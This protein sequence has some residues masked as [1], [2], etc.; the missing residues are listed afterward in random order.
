VSLWFA[1]V[2][3]AFTLAEGHAAERFALQLMWSNPAALAHPATKPTGFDQTTGLVAAAIVVMQALPL[4]FP[5]LSSHGGH[6]LADIACAMAS[7]IAAIAMFFLIARRW[8]ALRA[9][10]ACTLMSLGIAALFTTLAGSEVSAARPHVSAHLAF[11]LLGLAVMAGIWTWLAGVWQQQLDVAVAW[12]PAGRL[13]SIL[14][15]MVWL[16]A[17]LGAAIGLRLGLKASSAGAAGV[18]RLGATVAA[19]AGYLLLI[20]VLS[21][22]ARRWNRPF[23]L[24]LAALAAV[25]LAFLCFAQFG[26]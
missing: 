13:L 23:G 2:L 20:A 7:C 17:S 19:I 4:F 11:T 18:L 24:S 15:G 5:N 12:T 26:R 6:F 1:V 22:A 16:T 8:S 25:S 14:P 3:A 9:M 10:L 21:A